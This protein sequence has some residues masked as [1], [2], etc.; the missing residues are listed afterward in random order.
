MIG[1]LAL[2]EAEERIKPSLTVGL[3]PGLRLVIFEA[4]ESGD[5]WRIAVSL[6]LPGW[7]CAGA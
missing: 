5:A 6:A 4:S 1:G 3:L 2:F 7:G